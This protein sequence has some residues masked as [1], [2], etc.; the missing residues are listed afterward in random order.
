MTDTTT[1]R[2]LPPVRI[3][4]LTAA[5]A[6]LY[7]PLRLQA[8]RC[9]PDAFTSDYATAVNQPAEAYAARFTDPATGSF[10]L[11]AFDAAGGLIGSIGCETEQRPQQRHNALLVA[12]M[13]APAAQRHGVGRQLIDACVARAEAV[14]GLEQLTLTVTASNTHVV[15]LYE[16]AGFSAYGLLPRGIVV[17]GIGYD[18]LHMV[19][20]LR[21]SPLHPSNATQ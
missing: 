8:L 6:P 18:K 2:Y 12:M 4:V 9:F 13:V 19:R 16:R 1:D 7:K 10:F 21:A 17:A 11:G 5:H 3:Q 15:R 14:P 20:L